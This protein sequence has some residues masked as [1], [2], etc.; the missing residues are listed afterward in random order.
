[1]SVVPSHLKSVF[2]LFE[3][4]IETLPCQA[5]SENI[6]STKHC[7]ILWYLNMNLNNH[8]LKVVR[9]NTTSPWDV[10]ELPVGI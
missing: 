9:I 7:S 2:F 5:G 10:Y 1:M 8:T 3:S 6:C 4:R